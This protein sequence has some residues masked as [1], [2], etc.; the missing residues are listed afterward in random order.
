V[1]AAGFVVVAS[2]QVALAL[3]APFGRAAFGGAHAGTLPDEFRVVSAVAAGFW[4][5]AALHVVSR[6]GVIRRFRRLADSR[7][8]WVLAGLTA[9]GAL[10][11]AASSS[12]WER[13][14]W[15]PYTLSL[16]ILCVL[17]ARS[18]REGQ[19]RRDE[20]QS[21]RPIGSRFSAWKTSSV[22]PRAQ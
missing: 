1:A 11:N 19:S 3:G 16:S 15:A 5:L 6:G 21:M 14:G 8:T 10:M 12:P 22:R 13:F 18:G 4:A 9:L 20:R 17:L 7:I 2:F